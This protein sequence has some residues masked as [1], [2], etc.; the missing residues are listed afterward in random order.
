MVHE[1]VAAISRIRISF[2]IKHIDGTR[3]R[4]LVGA[5]ALDVARLLAA[6]ADALR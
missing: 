6:V 1:I 2:Q 4:S 3:K 5:G